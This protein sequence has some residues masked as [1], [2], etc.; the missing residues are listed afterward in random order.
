MS[1]NKHFPL[2]FSETKPSRVRVG[3][4]DWGLL[5]EADGLVDVSFVLATAQR[6]PTHIS[7]PIQ[8]AGLHVL[9]RGQWAQILFQCW[10]QSG[11][12]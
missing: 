12:K 8:A 11:I 1:N 6:F 7:H 3:E 10:Q 2:L 4:A 5:Q 9:V